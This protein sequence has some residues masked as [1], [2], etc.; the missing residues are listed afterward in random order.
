MR[1]PSRLIATR[2]VPSSA[3]GQCIVLQSYIV[4]P[5][6]NE[7]FAVPLVKL[8]LQNGSSLSVSAM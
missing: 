8:L 1:L 2:D 5:L 6:A 3:A 7:H 4:E